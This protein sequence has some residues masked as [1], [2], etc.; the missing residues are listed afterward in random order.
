MLGCLLLVG[1]SVAYRRRKGSTQSPPAWLDRLGRMHWLF[2]VG[3]GS[4]MLTYSLCVIAVAEILKAN[5]TGL[6]A[7]VAFVVFGLAS[8]TTIVMVAGRA[9]TA[10]NG[11]WNTRPAVP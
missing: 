9:V 2:A 3:V 4:L 8:I 10:M 7:G 5:V 11:A 1:S 6:D